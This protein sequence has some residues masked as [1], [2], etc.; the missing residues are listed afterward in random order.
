MAGLHIVL[1]ANQAWN[2]YNFR[3]GLVARFLALGCQISVLAPRDGYSEKLEDMGCRVFDLP[4]S[5]QG[6][7]PIA[8]CL[9]MLKMY[10]LYTTLKPN[11]VINYTIKPNIYGAIAARLA[12][13]PSLAVT[14]GLGYTFINDNLIAKTAR[15]MYRFAFQFPLE[16]WFL[17]LDDR[18]T[19]IRYG[20]VDPERTSVLH[21]EGCDLDYFAPR[22]KPLDDGNFRFLMIARML[23]DKGIAEYVSAAEVIKKKYPDAIFQLLGATGAENPSAVSAEQLQSWQSRG[24][25]EYLGVTDDVRP[26][27]AAADCVVLPSYREGVPRTLME[28]AAMAKPLIATDVPGCRELVIDRENG[29]LCRVRDAEDLSTKMLEVMQ[30]SELSRLALGRNGRANM[31]KIFDEKHTFDRYIRFL[32]E[33]GLSI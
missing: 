5:A 19:F 8:D 7:N 26:A 24:L 31:C 14:T 29:L 17:N 30:L 12:G 15:A 33:Q 20:L 32:N 3:R 1:S 13:V 2:I 11:L 27:I 28:A 16:I 18:Q 4:M 6:G 21:G 10:R 9:L 23:W 25:I 22:P